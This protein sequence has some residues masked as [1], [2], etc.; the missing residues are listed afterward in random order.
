MRNQHCL[1]LLLSL[2][3]SCQ[4]FAQRHTNTSI[5][6]GYLGHKFDDYLSSLE[7]FGLSGSFLVAQNDRIIFHKAYGYAD[8]QRGKRNTTNTLFSSGSLTTVFT[9]TAILKLEDGGVTQYFRSYF[10]LH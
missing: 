6:S 4:T 1:C 2:I 10:S 8:R 9:A 3:L 7:P 5:S